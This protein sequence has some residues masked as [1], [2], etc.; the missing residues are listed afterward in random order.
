MKLILTSTVSPDDALKAV[1]EKFD[2]SF[3]GESVTEIHVPVFP[4][5]FQIGLIVGSSGSGKTTL[6]RSQFGDEEQ[7][8]WDNRKAV[9]SNFAS[10]DDGIELLC[11]AGLSSIPAW[12]KPYSVLSTG[13]KFR[14]D[15]ARRLRD[16]AV[17]DEF[18]SVVNRETAKSCSCSIQKYI[19]RKGLK[20]IVFASCHDDISGFLQPDWVY[21]TDTTQFYNGRYL[22]RERITL[23]LH[24][25]TTE[26]WDMFKKHHYLSADL[27]KSCS[28]YCAETNGQ[29]VAFVSALAFPFGGG[30]HA[31]REH[32]LVVLPDFQGIGIGNAVSE[33]IAQ[34]YIEKGC[35]YFSKTANPKCGIHRDNSKLWRPTSHNHQK[36]DDYLKDGNVRI[37]GRHSMS[38]EMQRI[39][40]KRICYSHE[41]IG[42]GTRYEYTYK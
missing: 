33:A 31:W 2:Y 34:G 6:L 32:R 27:N 40:A 11:A 42:D 10:V 22:Q 30:S 19:R 39:H 3:S 7:V 16:N 36:R 15:I 24:P 12:C 25:C 38:E 28:C 29:P 14:A 4:E 26:L 35:R 17:I 1:T 8:E 21:N 23:N 20:R 18:T 9:I 13:E 5:D 37:T 41:Y